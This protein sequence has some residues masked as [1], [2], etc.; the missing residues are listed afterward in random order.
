MSRGRKLLQGAAWIYGSQVLTVLAQFAYAAVT[1]R[2]VGPAGFGSYAIA[3]AVSGLVSLI[4]VGGIG[5][6]VSRM[7]VIDDVRLRA[8]VTFALLVGLGAAALLW[9]TAPLWA[10][11]WG[12]PAAAPVLEVLTVSAFTAPLAGVG[13]SLMRRQGSFRAIAILSLAANL[14]GMFVGAI[15]VATWRSGTSLVVSAVIAQVALLVGVLLL[16]KRRL[17]GL[18]WPKHAV[19]EV[20][21]SANLTAV[22]IAEYLVGNILKFSVSR[23]LGSAFFGYWNRADMVATLPFQQVQT[24]LVQAVSPEFRNDIESSRRAHRV[25]TD[26][27]V[28]VA[29]LVI[30]LCTLAA[31]GLPAVV[32]YL[33]G[34]GWEV[35]AQITTPL[36]LAAGMQTVSMVLSS[37]IETLGRYKW[38]WLT[39]SVL[40]V[41]QIFGAIMLFVVGDIA[42]AMACLIITQVARHAVQI[43]LC[44]KYGY[45]DI[46]S[47]LKNYLVI[48]LFAAVVG[49]EA[50]VTLSLVPVAVREPF[51]LAIPVVLLTATASLTFIF[52]KHIP[53]V[54]VAARYGIGRSGRR[55]YAKQGA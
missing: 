7:V 29:W 39:S 9:L 24:A 13:A 1:S 10:A 23:A 33:F 34:P 53:V 11:L 48:V 54:R 40:I 28:L 36:A 44:N 45:I 47:L 18:A 16:T 55:T 30:P 51:V 17:W 41:I 20:I 14:L 31:V 12:D 5:Q 8:L 27:L 37:A 3:L 19:G 50:L 38:M 22:K 26:M 46:S 15:A 4:A 52:R 2:L 25:W 21:F 32:P 6:A 42:I 43:A 35:T 49:G